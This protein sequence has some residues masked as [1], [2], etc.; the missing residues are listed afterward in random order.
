MFFGTKVSPNNIFY[1]GLNLKLGFETFAPRWLCPFSTTTSEDIA[2]RFSKES[3]IILKLKPA[4]GS[5][6]QF[7]NTEWLSNYRDEKERLFTKAYN[8]QIVD[9]QYIEGNHWK[10]NV[11]YLSALRLFST[12]FD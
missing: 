6:E 5:D 12:L 7:F 10:K 1:T 9:I 11:N 4:P 3:G 2:T 8:L